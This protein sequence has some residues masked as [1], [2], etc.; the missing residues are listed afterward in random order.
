MPR[1]S[2]SARHQSRARPRVAISLASSIQLWHSIMSPSV[3][4]RIANSTRSARHWQISVPAGLSRLGS[5]REG[6]VAQ[7]RIR[8]PTAPAAAVFSSTRM[9]PRSLPSRSRSAPSAHAQV[10]PAPRQA[11]TW[12]QSRVRD[13]RLYVP[14]GDADLV[15]DV[16]VRDDI[17]MI[18]QAAEHVNRAAF[19][20]LWVRHAFKK[21]PCVGLRDAPA[22]SVSVQRAL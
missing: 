7:A 20:A 3:N 9:S 2:R 4:F 11:G 15:N 1:E 17:G 21:R 5:A 10:P 6:P 13:S 19:R 8:R 18:G 16:S 22:S 14:S 12:V